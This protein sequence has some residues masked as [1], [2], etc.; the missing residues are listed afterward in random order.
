[1]LLLEYVVDFLPAIDRGSDWNSAL[2]Q[3]STR[4]NHSLATFLNVEMVTGFPCLFTTWKISQNII[5]K[6][7]RNWVMTLQVYWYGPCSLKK[8]HH[9]FCKLPLHFWEE[10]CLFFF[11]KNNCTVLTKNVSLKY[12][13]CTANYLHCGTGGGSGCLLFSK[14]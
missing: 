9:L 1:M 3:L 13:V 4:S 11:A 6:H 7:S 2:M 10:C 14:K 8:F 5:S 12:Y